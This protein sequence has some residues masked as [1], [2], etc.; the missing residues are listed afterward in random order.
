MSDDLIE[1]LRDLLVQATKERSHFYVASC[2]REAINEIERLQ[3]RVDE[4][5]KDINESNDENA[6]Y[7]DKIFEQKARI[8]ELEAALKEQI[9]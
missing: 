1:K 2:T 9:K 7:I 4:L 3:S 8:S 5:E 6:A